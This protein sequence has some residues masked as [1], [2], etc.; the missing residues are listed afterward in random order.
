MSRTLSRTRTVA[1]AAFGQS[2]AKIIAKPVVFDTQQT[3]EQQLLCKLQMYATANLT[4]QIFPQ[5]HEA[6]LASHTVSSLPDSLTVD[7][8]CLGPL[9]G[10][11]AHLFHCSDRRP[12]ASSNTV[13]VP[14]FACLCHASASDSTEQS[15]H[16]DP[17]MLVTV[18]HAIPAFRRSANRHANFG[19][20]FD[21]FQSGVLCWLT[22]CAF[23]RTRRGIHRWVFGRTNI[24]HF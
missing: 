11:P 21:W 24:A 10:D 14:I 17:H 9:P 7:S 23:A 4:K 22:V 18:E 15:V 1:I 20:R 3:H 19:S 16:V 12:D 2:T 5:T 8:D 6:P 13:G